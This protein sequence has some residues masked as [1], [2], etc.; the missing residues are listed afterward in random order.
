MNTIMFES[1]RSRTDRIGMQSPTSCG[2]NSNV[3]SSS[4]TDSDGPHEVE[5]SGQARPNVLFEAGMAMGRDHG[6]TILVE[7]GVVRPFSDVAGLHVVRLDDTP[8]RRQELAQRLRA[9]G[10]V[11]N[12][13]GSDWYRADRFGG[14]VERVQRSSELSDTE[15]RPSDGWTS[16]LSEEAG[17]LLVEAAKSDGAIYK[18]Q[19]CRRVDSEG[20]WKILRGNR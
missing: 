12:T 5:L 14:A 8:E 11:V 9:A 18:D 19:I 3:A 20:K 7:L 2:K 1:I 6:R 10:C 4:R 17:V 16:D 13:D 15:A